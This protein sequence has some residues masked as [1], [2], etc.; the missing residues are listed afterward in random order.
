LEK[1]IMHI[2]E[3]ELKM[4]REKT[5]IDEIHFY[6]AGINSSDHKKRIE[7]CLKQFFGL[8]KVQVYSDM[9][10]AARATCL[11]NKGIA[12]IL[13]TGSN[14]CYFDGKKIGFKTHTL[15]YVLG[16]E[17]GGTHLGKK[18]LQYFLHDIFDQDLKKKFVAQFDAD[19]DVI[20]D[21]IY[22]KPLP[23]RYLAGFASFIFENRGHYMIENIAEDCLNDL[24]INH[25]LRYPHIHKL[26]VH[27]TGSVA[28]YL[29]DILLN[30]CG[31]YEIN[32]G[33][34]IQKP[35]KGLISYHSN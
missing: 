8:N 22:R 10:A 35:M 14:T 5:M 24:F 9:L 12:C 2:F 3:S 7:K 1:E 28:F 21:S 34:V 4:K 20:L 27:F 32:C 31:Q 15:G 11:H 13:G 30:M 25:L 18:I 17:G 16:D 23:N 19:K 6:G 26:P 29:K 33:S